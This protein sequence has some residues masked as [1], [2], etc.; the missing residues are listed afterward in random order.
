MV[1]GTSKKCI[2]LAF[3]WSTPT[4]PVLG[5]TSV[6]VTRDCLWEREEEE[7]VEGLGRKWHEG[8][9]GEGECLV[10]GALPVQRE[11]AQ[12]AV[13]PGPALSVGGC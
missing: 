7:G 10:C 5:T 13:G 9:E 2:V 6:T 8:V 12:P 11:P 4:S 1:K 3:T